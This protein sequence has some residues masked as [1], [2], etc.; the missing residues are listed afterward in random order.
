MAITFTYALTKDKRHFGI[1]VKAIS[2][3]ALLELHPRIPELKP[4][5]YALYSNIDSK[6]IVKKGAV[7]VQ[8][9]RL[10]RV[11]TE[12]KAKKLV[13]KLNAMPEN[14]AV[15]K[16]WHL[17][18]KP[19]EKDLAIV[20]AQYYQVHNSLF[21]EPSMQFTTQ[22][23]TLAEQTAINYAR[24]NV[25]SKLR[26]T[27]SKNLVVA[28]RDLEHVSNNMELKAIQPKGARQGEHNPSKR[29][30]YMKRK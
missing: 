3:L 24:S 20:K 18:L 25:P 14:I 29:T 11:N 26:K 22:D 6:M 9:D 13:K 17:Y 1:Y 19:V 27:V 15:N 23:K 8:S 30:I 7:R 16:V 5:D 21:G 4:E 2:G 10:A 12:K 28:K